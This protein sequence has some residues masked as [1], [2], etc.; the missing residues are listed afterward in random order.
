M[1]ILILGH[2]WDLLGTSLGHVLPFSSTAQKLADMGALEAPPT[3]PGFR[4][5][6]FERR[7]CYPASIT[8]IM[9]GQ[10]NT[11]MWTQL[12]HFVINVVV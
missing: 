6:C 9:V 1:K 5:S 10:L 12:L 11:S 3:G 7:R 2:I 4:C 8:Y